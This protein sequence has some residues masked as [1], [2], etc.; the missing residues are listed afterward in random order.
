MLLGM[1]LPMDNYKISC[2]FDYFILF[3]C[4]CL[5]F[6]AKFRGEDEEGIEILEN[7]DN[8]ILSLL[9]FIFYT[10][11]YLFTCHLSLNHNIVNN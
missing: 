4:F 7:Y 11:N 5:N 8:L 1:F 3:Y 9:L 2:S 10:L 6:Y